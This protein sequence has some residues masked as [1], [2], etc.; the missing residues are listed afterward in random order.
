MDGRCRAVM[1][2]L[3]GSRRPKTHEPVD[4]PFRQ[5]DER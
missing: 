3:I 4:M 1:P 5:E 2:E